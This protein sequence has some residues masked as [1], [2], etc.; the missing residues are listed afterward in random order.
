MTYYSYGLALGHDIALG[1]IS[2]IE[3]VLLPYTNNILL[4]PRTQPIERHPV[5]TAVLSGRERGD[6]FVNHEWFW[7]FM[8]VAAYD[9]YNDT[10]FNGVVSV[11]VTVLQRNHL[12]NVYERWNGYAHRP[13]AGT[14]FVYDSYRVLEV[15]QRFTLTTYLPES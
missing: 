8:P 14:E 4:P 9:F 12:K 11:A 13:I 3:T 1:S 15:T 5:R 10:Y 7:G 2:N 6:G